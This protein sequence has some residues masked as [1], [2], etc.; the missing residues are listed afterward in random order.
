MRILVI[1][2]AVKL[3]S[4]IRRGLREE[5]L[6]ADVAIRREEALWMTASTDYDAIVLD[7]MLPG[8]RFGASEALIS[9]RTRELGVP[10]GGPSIV[11]YSGSR[12]GRCAADT[13]LAPGARRPLPP[14]C[15]SV[16]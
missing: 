2:D 7:V 14:R 11:R 9:P 12:A 1:E 15:G 13:Y 3:A 6:L 8:K 10:F 5:G 16:G 4:L